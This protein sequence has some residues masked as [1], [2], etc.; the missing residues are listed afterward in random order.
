MWLRVGS[1]RPE[2]LATQYG[3]KRPVFV[4]STWLRSREI[5]QYPMRYGYVQVGGAAHGVL[6]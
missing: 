4:Q 2:Y 3:M 1:G 6:A 5:F